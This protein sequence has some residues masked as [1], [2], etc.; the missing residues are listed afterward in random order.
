MIRRLGRAF[1]VGV[2]VGLIAG[3]S[4]GLGLGISLQVPYGRELDE[5]RTVHTDSILAAYQLQ[6][7]EGV[8]CLQE[9]WA[10][11]RPGLN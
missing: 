11:S 10:L 6:T 3:A 9:A 2:A 8:L 4:L 5:R 1:A 7:I